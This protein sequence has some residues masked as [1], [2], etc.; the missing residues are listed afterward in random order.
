MSPRHTGRYGTQVCIATCPQAA[1]LKIT[2][3]D[4]VGME[5]GHAICHVSSILHTTRVTTKLEKGGENKQ[6]MEHMHDCRCENL[7]RPIFSCK[8]LTCRS[9]VMLTPPVA[10]FLSHPPCSSL[11]RVPPLASSCRG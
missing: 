10:W 6:T 8:H 2:M 5:V 7:W 3:D 1:Y 11:S 4:A 9:S